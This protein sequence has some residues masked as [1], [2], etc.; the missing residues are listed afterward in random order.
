MA[1]M[2][3]EERAELDFI[4]AFEK[5]EYLVLSRCRMVEC[6]S[7]E[8]VGRSFTRVS[9]ACGHGRPHHRSL[10]QTELRIEAIRIE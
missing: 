10:F 6:R 8:G 5:T 2:L 3:Y 1:A 9:P 7:A 4:Y